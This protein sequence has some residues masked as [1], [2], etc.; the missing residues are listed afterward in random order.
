MCMWYPC[1]MYMIWLLWNTLCRLV[2][3]CIGS[4]ITI[5]NS[6]LYKQ[7]M[8]NLIAARI[9]GDICSNKCIVSTGA[10][11]CNSCGPLKCSL[12][13]STCKPTPHHELI[14]WC[15]GLWFVDWLAD[16]FVSRL[17]AWRFVL[18]FVLFVG[19]GVC[20]CFG[21]YVHTCRQTCVQI[22][23]HILVR[24]CIRACLHA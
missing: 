23:T 1:G 17:V 6:L 15:C 21:P 2:Y 14:C 12:R 7:H 18:L 8:F 22:R 24:T 13:G 16:E 4:T 11:P 20:S 10:K 5:N 9:Y 19:L 3:T